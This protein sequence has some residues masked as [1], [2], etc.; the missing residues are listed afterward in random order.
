MARGLPTACRFHQGP[1]ATISRWKIGRNQFSMEFKSAEL[2]GYIKLVCYGPNSTESIFGSCPTI[3][4]PTLRNDCMN[5]ILFHRGCYNP[6]HCGHKALLHHVYDN[7]QDINVIAAII[8]P[9]DDQGL[10]KKY[11]S[12][13]VLFSK[14]QRI[15]LWCG[16]QQ[17]EW[18]WIYEDNVNR[19]FGTF[20][21]FSVALSNA[22]A[23]D[24]FGLQFVILLGPDHVTTKFAPL[25]GHEE[26]I[27]GDVTRAADFVTKRGDPLLQLPSYEPWKSVEVDEDQAR[28]RAGDYAAFLEA[29]MSQFVPVAYQALIQKSQ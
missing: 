29:R 22:A 18:C 12:G 26:I 9:V 11:G 4:P 1:S 13:A 27:V 25:D 21:Q 7:T 2:A 5:R 24:G 14:E 17:P 10:E 6:P 19:F 3:Q 23:R 8:D 28:R 15:R 20:D 16:Y